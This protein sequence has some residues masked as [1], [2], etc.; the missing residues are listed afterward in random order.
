MQ[1][2]LMLL[3]KHIGSPT[4]KRLA[5]S[6]LGVFLLSTTGIALAYYEYHTNTLAAWMGNVLAD[7]NLKRQTTG[8]IWQHLQSREK[9]LKTLDQTSTNEVPEIP[10]GLPEAVARSRFELRR[11]P[12]T[13]LP[14]YWALW[15]TRLTPQERENRPVHDVISSLHR[16]RLGLPLLKA[17][18]L[19][20]TRY[21]ARVK[22]ELDHLYQQ[23]GDLTLEPTEDDTLAWFSPDSLKAAVYE[24]LNQDMLHQFEKE[25]QAALIQDFQAGLIHQILLHRG[26]GSYRGELTFHD[27]Q[28]PTIT[29]RLSPKLLAEALHIAQPDSTHAPF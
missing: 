20:D 27:P 18:D 11:A 29:F 19:P 13:G 7:T 12:E 3:R 15:N 26:L 4:G 25:E 24:T 22:Q 2:L 10:T 5:I 9:V 6:A 21:R 1:T 28:R 17:I 16:Y 14:G 23:A 8:T